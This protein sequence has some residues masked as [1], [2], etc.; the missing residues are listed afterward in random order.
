VRIAIIGAGPR[1]TFALERLVQHA[2]AAASMP[3]PIAVDLFEPHPHPGAGPVY[4]PRQPDYLRMNL[5]VEHVD[6]RLDGDA[7]SG[8]QSF[9]EWRDAAAGSV[10]VAVADSFPSRSL[11]GRYLVAMHD[12]IRAGSLPN[13]LCTLVPRRVRQLRRHAGGWMVRCEPGEPGE[14]E[15]GPYDEVLLT[16]G[17]ADRHAAGLQVGWAHAVPLV[18]A[19]FPVDRTLDETAVPAGSVVAIR[20][21]ALTGIDAL[22]ALTEGRGGRFHTIADG[23]EFRYEPAGREPRLVLP[24]SRSGQLMSAKP[25]PTSLAHHAPRLTEIAVAA[26]ARVHAI[27]DPLDV[28]AA[29]LPILS[30]AASAIMA[31]FDA[32]DE[33]RDGDVQDVQAWLRDAVADRVHVHD[34]LAQLRRSIDFGSGRAAPDAPS[35]IGTAW[36][37]AYPAVVAHLADAVIADDERR[38]LARLT[39]QLERV[40]FGPPPVSA[41]KL[42]ALIEC[43]IVD[44]RHRAGGHLLTTH[45]RTQLSSTGTP[46]SIDVVVDAVLAP[47][48]ARRV[49]DPIIASLL[50][51]GHARLLPERRGIDVD[52][53]ARVIG[54][55][56]EPV[57]GLAAIGR[58][59]EDVVV[60]NDTLSRTL[61]AHD[62]RWARSVVAAAARRC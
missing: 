15:H 21:I 58:V 17:H 62:E 38:R 19:V 44:L 50:Q 52:D 57:D 8:L 7:I 26:Q 27:A 18:P 49:H 12:A 31:A 60:G 55:D 43:G 46:T 34:P 9:M 3:E 54:S 30:W 47:P 37:L 28:R 42:A 29:L 10:A 1:G 41:A 53:D 20:G 33:P 25:D 32:A 51:D 23:S 59:T 48:G 22:L 4:D 11:V 45:G 13:V 40:A 61:H 6:V 56:G 35:A 16:T 14:L 39:A 36:R 2:A 24:Y 5:A